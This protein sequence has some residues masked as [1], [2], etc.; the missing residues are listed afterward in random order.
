LGFFVASFIFSQFLL[1]FGLCNQLVTR[2]IPVV[3]SRLWTNRRV[4]DCFLYNGQSLMLLIR[5]R[6]LSPLV[7]AFILGHS[8]WTHSGR[9]SR[10]VTY[11]PYDS[12]I[13][14]FSNQLRPHHFDLRTAGSDPWDRENAARNAL[15]EG[16]TLQHPRPRD[17]VSVS[18]I[19]EILNPSIVQY[20]K[21]HPPDSP[22]RVR[23]RFFYYS[24]RWELPDVWTL[25]A[26]MCY[27]QIDHPLHYYRFAPVPFSKVFMPSTVA[28]ALGRFPKS[29]AS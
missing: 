10:P 19:D 22:L 27:G 24:F 8:N 1:V 9:H 25:N 6:T 17:V 7:S 29:F 21:E 28:I 23:A 13:R 26:V 16:L 2:R 3:S 14:A 18:D 4:F 15:M 20:F 5:L 11:S 12:E